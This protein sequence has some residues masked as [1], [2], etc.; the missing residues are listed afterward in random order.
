MKKEKGRRE[1]GEGERK[2][3]EKGDDVHRKEK[4]EALTLRNMPVPLSKA[5]NYHLQ[6][7]AVVVRRSSQVSR[8][9]PLTAASSPGYGCK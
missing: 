9:V 2:G 4:Q 7:K 6:L 8:S 3:S 1:W 5:S